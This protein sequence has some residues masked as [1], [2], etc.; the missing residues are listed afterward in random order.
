MATYKSSRELEGKIL[1]KDD[2]LE[3]RVKEKTL[4]YRVLPR[5]LM[6]ED[7][8]HEQIF[9]IL[10]IKDRFQYAKKYYQEAADFKDYQSFPECV[11]DSYEALTRLAIALFK[12]CEKLQEGAEPEKPLESIYKVG[13]K[14]KVK[15]T[16]DSGYSYADYPCGFTESMLEKFGGEVVTITR[17]DYRDSTYYSARKRYLEPFI[18]IVAE[19]EDYGWSAAMF[20]GKVED[21]PTEDISAKVPIYPERSNDNFYFTKEDIPTNCP[22]HPYVIDQ[23]IQ[24]IHKVRVLSYV[25]ALKEIQQEPKGIFVWFSWASTSQGYEYWD[26]IDKDP[27]YCPEDYTPVFY[28]ETVDEE[29]PSTEISQSLSISSYEIP[30]SYEEVTLS[31]TKPKVFF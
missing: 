18:Y 19:D 10:G 15:S 13:D 27:S 12:D 7:A 23:A 16:Y 3:F 24:E 21:T 25:D 2:H 20:E 5:F 29:D 31:I 4:I 26:N 22:Y 28:R 17:V 9:Y 1:K 8:I 30:C 14:V 11:T 6:R